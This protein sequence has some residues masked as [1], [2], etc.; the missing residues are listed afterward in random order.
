[1]TKKRHPRKGPRHLAPARPQTQQQRP[2]RGIADP[3]EAQLI[4]DVR[5]AMRMDHPIDLLALVSAMLAAL[6]PRRATPFAQPSTAHVS[7]A[8]LFASFLDVRLSETSAILSVVAA[9]VEDELLRARIDRELAARRSHLPLWLSD[10]RGLDIYRTLEMGHVLGDGDNIMLGVRL[11]TGEE[12]TAVVY[13]DHNVGTLV[14]D[15]FIVAEPIEDV[16]AL[17]R[18]E[19]DVDTTYDD[20]DPASARARIEDAIKTASITFPPFETDTWPACQPMIEWFIRQLPTG[21]TGY[22]FREWDDR[23]LQ[24]IAKRF[25]ASPY[26]AAFGDAAHRDMLDVILGFGA[27]H[28][29]GDPLRWSAVTVEILLTD[30][31]PRKVVADV[32]DLEKVPDLLR[33]FISFSHAERGIRSTHTDEALAA[34][35]AWEPEYRETISSPRLQ[36]PEAL[37]A[38][39][40]LLDPDS[41]ESALD[42]ALARLVMTRLHDAVGDEDALRRLRPDPLPDEAFDWTGIPEDLH[43]TIATVLALC[44][45]CCDELFDIE[46]RT[47]C[48]RLLGDLAR[49]D[50]ALFPASTRVDITAAGVCWIVA[51]ANSSFGTRPGEVRVKDLT[52]HFGLRTTPSQRGNALLRSGIVGARVTDVDALGSPRYLTSARRRKIIA[53]RDREARSHH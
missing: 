26:G 32:D 51:K 47:A 40:G 27:G 35:A 36:G 11:P 53:A 2:D 4:A 20:I 9:M 39:M 14:K 19:A 12:M 23:E 15:A 10:L 49:T 24:D 8:D 52:A 48:R 18:R 28:G 33:A 43:E 29:L 41:P 37:L 17:T 6:E 44:D 25:L 16:I 31:L 5:R 46:H 45:R 42:A 34:V 50:S 38:K 13:I 3:Q 30:W 7:R 22:E 1:M 21:G